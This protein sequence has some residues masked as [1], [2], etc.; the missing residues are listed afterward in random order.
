VG[1][2]VVHEV[3]SISSVGRRSDPFDAGDEYSA[4]VDRH[5]RY[6]LGQY[7]TPRPVTKY[8]V[9]CLDA[10]GTS[11]VFDP[12]L[13]TGNLLAMLDRNV[14]VGGT[15]IDPELFS[16]CSTALHALGFKRVELE[17]TNF[18]EYRAAHPRRSFSRII[19]NPPYIRNHNFPTE[20]KDELTDRYAREFGVRLHRSSSSYVYFFLEALL[21]LKE[22]GRMVFLTPV[23]FLEARY[24][25]AL[26]RVLL[27]YSVVRFVSFNVTD[28]LFD[29]TDTTSCVTVLDKRPPP[30]GHHVEFATARVSGDSVTVGRSTSVPITRLDPERPWTPFFNDG[31]RSLKNFTSRRTVQLSRYMRVRRGILTGCNSFFTLD[32]K[33]RVEWGVERKYLV[34]VVH[35]ANH[36]RGDAFTK[37]DWEAL[38]KSGKRCWLL[39]CHEPKSGLKGTGVL[40]YIEFGEEMGVNERYTCSSREPWYSVEKIDPPD[41]IISYM[42]RGKIRFVR[43]TSG[44]VVLT[45]LLAGYL[46]DGTVSIDRLLGVLRS[47]E[48]ASVLDVLV[49][50]YSGGLKKIEPNTLKRLPMIEL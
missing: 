26:R 28:R 23:E 40:R 29:N 10:D 24:G 6:S 33:T 39:S 36:V 35:K 15:E 47:D 20:L 31:Y 1:V 5:K 19:C 9:E 18:F 12:A 17:N 34:P 14:R 3:G 7:F 27:R 43:N 16:I 42:T 50:S 8:M 48:T 21:L 45:N 32:E 22:G 37:G 49:K 4:G 44:C 30:E 46:V 13:G 41:V 38:K 2:R 25:V 11:E